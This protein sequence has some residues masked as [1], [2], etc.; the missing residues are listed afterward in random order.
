[1]FVL[2]TTT[3]AAT[4]TTQGHLDVFDYRL[5]N[6]RVGSDPSI[7]R[8]RQV[9]RHGVGVVKQGRGAARGAGVARNEAGVGGGAR[10]DGLDV[11]RSEAL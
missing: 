7:S 8:G 11:R 3:A 6:V 5:D 9:R 2:M 4:A 1:M 10:L